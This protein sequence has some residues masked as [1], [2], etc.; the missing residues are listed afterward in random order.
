[1]PSGRV[2]PNGNTRMRFVVPGSADGEHR[3]ALTSVADAPTPTPIVPG[4]TVL[5]ERP[6]LVRR[7][8]ATPAPSPTPAS[9]PSPSPPPAPTPTPSPTPAPSPTPTAPPSSAFVARDGAR[10]EVAGEPYRF[11][12]LNI[13]NANSRWTCWYDMQSDGTLDRALGDAGSGQEAFRA[14]FF[15]RL[16]TTNGTR[17][18]TAFDRTIAAAKKRGVRI[19]ATLA[20]QWGDCENDAGSPVY[21]GEWWY[22]DGYRAID[23]AG[24]VSYRDWVREIA[25]RYSNEPTILAWQ[26]MNEAEALTGPGGSCS[27]TAEASL[28]AWARDTAAIVKAAD[29]NHLLSLGTIGN[30]QCGTSSGVSYERLHAIPSV[31]LCE[32]HDYDRPDEPMPGDQWNGL[33]VRLGQCT[34]LAKPMFVGE[35]G[36]RVSGVGAPSARAAAF[37]KK[38]AAQFGA[39]VSGI[40]LWDWRTSE[41][42]GTGTG[43]EIGP[44]DPVLALLASY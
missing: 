1:M 16:A 15:Q 44:G 5:A 38:F 2:L 10:L 31:D 17:D 18:W 30:G 9:S 40:L 7:I 22:R 41:Q 25:S 34:L 20:N 4:G 23:P 13:Y 33:A 26:L 29:P 42:G 11:T 19:V 8:A 14:W 32:Y 6:F 27:A 35:S 43:Y 28:E 37:D 36:L 3:V 21:K 12:G 24:T 39:G